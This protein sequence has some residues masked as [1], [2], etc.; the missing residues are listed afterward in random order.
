LKRDL[1]LPIFAIAALAPTPATAQEGTDVAALRAEI[2]RMR[3]QLEQLEAR[4][5]KIEDGKSQDGKAGATRGAEAVAV[6]AATA[7]EQPNAQLAAAPAPVVALPASAVPPSSV[8]AVTI[9]PRGRLQFDTN[10]ISRPDGMT[11]PT[12]GWSTDVRRAF[13]GVDGK[14]G[15]GFGFRLEVDFA[16][17]TPQF[18]DNWLTYE[19]GPLTITLGNH[20]L[21]TLEDLTSDLETSFLE[22]SAFVGAFGFERRIG[23]SF[24]YVKGD[25]MLNVGAFSDDPDTLGATGVTA[26]SYALDSRF[27]FMPKLGGTQFH[28]AGSLHHREL[29]DVTTS[30][31]YRARPGARTTDVRF[32]DTGTFS[33]TAETGYGLEF[34]AIHGPVHVASEA[35][36][37]KVERPNLATPTFFGSYGEIGYVFAGG[38]TRSYKNGSFGSIKP[39]SG[40]DKGGSGAWQVNL[41][42][43]WLD[44]SSSG[45]N[46]GKQSTVG[47][48]LVWVPIEHVKFLANYL[49]INVSDTPVLA[50]ARSD[51]DADVI[52]LRAQYDF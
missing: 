26:N 13:L 52:G 12:L 44:L 1:F 40:L 51:Y 20:R 2:S 42:Y 16:P 36:W 10:Y 3:S 39:T 32:V 4:L 23:L 14:L 45:V 29:N 6:V 34:A 18:T 48:S 7:A 25:V 19:N 46:G 47:A 8:S 30:L 35:F 43:D 41:R 49:R 9:K 24:A 50:G 17:G 11:P 22:R 27:V 31:R 21:T 37:Q 15:G 33:A 28:L 38:R 5:G